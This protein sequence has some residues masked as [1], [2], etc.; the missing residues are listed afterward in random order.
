M[1]GKDD[2]KRDDVLRRMLKTPP[3]P[4]KSSGKPENG[5]DDMPTDPDALIEWAKRNIKTD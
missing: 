5:V 2:S 1:S 3:T 4:H